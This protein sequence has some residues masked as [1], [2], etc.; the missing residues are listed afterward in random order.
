M[1]YAYQGQVCKTGET[2]D[3]AVFTY[4][5]MED[6]LELVGAPFYAKTQKEALQFI[7]DLIEDSP[8]KYQ[9]VLKY[10]PTTHLN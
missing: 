3:W 7:V 4:S 10:F 2:T 8:D 1:N 9:I 5:K 6:N